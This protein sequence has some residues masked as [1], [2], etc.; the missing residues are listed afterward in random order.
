[1][2]Q[3][4]LII[5]SRHRPLRDIIIVFV[6]RDQTIDNVD[7]GELYAPRNSLTLL[8]LHLFWYI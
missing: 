3:R 6:Q 5:I 7:S 4:I 1:M 8:K 2:A